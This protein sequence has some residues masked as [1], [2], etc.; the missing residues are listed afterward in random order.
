MPDT[1]YRVSVSLPL[2]YD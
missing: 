2:I 1:N